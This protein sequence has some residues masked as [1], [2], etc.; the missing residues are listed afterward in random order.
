MTCR[1]VIHGLAV[2]SGESEPLFARVGPRFAGGRMAAMAL[3]API[4][5]WPRGLRGRCHTA[6]GPW[7]LCV[8]T[9]ALSATVHY[10]GDGDFGNSRPNSRQAFQKCDTLSMEEP[11]HFRE[12]QRGGHQEHRTAAVR[13]SRAPGVARLLGVPLSRA[14]TVAGD[15]VWKGSPTRS[16]HTEGG[17]QLKGTA[18]PETRYTGEL[19]SR[20]PER[21]GG[22]YR[23]LTTTE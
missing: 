15:Q 10:S 8:K 17:G 9:R 11:A 3:R 23:H 14:R 18:M 4:E 2:P 21:G 5:T 7:L 20:T 1:R 16:G 6:D 12:G 13:R 22:T 19:D